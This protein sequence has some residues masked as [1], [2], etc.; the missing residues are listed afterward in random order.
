MGA[1]GWAAA[2][3]AAVAG[4]FLVALLALAVLPLRLRLAGSTSPAPRLRVELGLFG[5]LVPRLTAY[6][7]ARGVAKAKAR[8]GGAAETTPAAARERKRRRGVPPWLRGRWPALLRGVPRLLADLLACLRIEHL[9]VDG[10]FGLDDP[11]DTGRVWGMLAPLLYAVPPL[12]GVA[13]V[14][15]RFDG[16]TLSGDAEATLRLVPAALLPPA[17]RFAWTVARGGRR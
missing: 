13:T 10:E 17:L 7:S 16:A 8:R 12:A 1:I 6:D 5:G 15:P 4:A 11:A 3:L 9:H 2:A 14:R